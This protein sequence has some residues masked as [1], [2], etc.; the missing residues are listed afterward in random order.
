MDMYDKDDETIQEIITL[1][2]IIVLLFIMT[3]K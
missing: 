1:L 2:G 3:G